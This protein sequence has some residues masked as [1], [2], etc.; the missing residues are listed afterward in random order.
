MP[1]LES[2]EAAGINGR[3]EGTFRAFS[4]GLGASKEGRPGGAHRIGQAS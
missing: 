3:L 2:V 1:I 4:G